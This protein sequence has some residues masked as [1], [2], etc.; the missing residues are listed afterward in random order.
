M[1]GQVIFRVDKK[2]KE[3]ALRKAHTQGFPFSSILKLATKAFV[4]GHLEVGL[5]EALPFNASAHKDITRSLRDINQ[6]KNLSP[7]FRSAKE[8][9]KYLTA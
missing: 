6:K 3:Q 1:T 2:L 5:F 7:S 8:A 4:D 9:A